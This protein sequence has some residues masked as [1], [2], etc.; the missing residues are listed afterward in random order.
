LGG[1]P[2]IIPDVP[3]TFVYLLI[4]MALTIVHLKILKLNKSQGHKFAFSG[5]TTGTQ[6]ESS[7]QRWLTNFKRFV[8]FVSLL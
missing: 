5:A 7:S 3:I 2:T 1:V 8:Q 6:R 4:Y